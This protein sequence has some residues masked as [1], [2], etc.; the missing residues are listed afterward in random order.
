MEQVELLSVYSL[1]CTTA[2]TQT[3]C[4]SLYCAQC[5][6][7][8]VEIFLFTELTLNVFCPSTNNAT[9]KWCSVQLAVDMVTVV[10]TGKGSGRC[11]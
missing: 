5:C 3:L 4:C 6:S 8:T 1:F 2:V 11:K 7:E 10:G 9:Y